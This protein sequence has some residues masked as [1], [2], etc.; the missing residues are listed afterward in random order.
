[1]ALQNMRLQRGMQPTM[2]TTITESK[3]IVSYKPITRESI[4]KV[5]LVDNNDID[6]H[7]FFKKL[8]R[9]S[10]QIPE[11]YIQLHTQYKK[12]F[13]TYFEIYKLLLKVSHIQ[14]DY[15]PNCSN[16]YHCKENNPQYGKGFVCWNNWTVAGRPK[17]ISLYSYCQEH[18]PKYDAVISMSLLDEHFEIITKQKALFSFAKNI[19]S[20]WERNEISLEER[21]V[22]TAYDWLQLRKTIQS[23]MLYTFNRS[24][25]TNILIYFYNQDIE[26]IQIGKEALQYESVIGEILTRSNLPLLPRIFKIKY[27]GTNNFA[28]KKMDYHTKIDN[29]HHILEVFTWR[30]HQEKAQQVKDYAFLLRQ[31][32]IN[33][34]QTLLVE[35]ER[36]IQNEKNEIYGIP[37]LNEKTLIDYIHNFTLKGFLNGN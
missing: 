15:T 20:L 36:Y 19:Q 11:K 27:E 32:G 33:N 35:K 25:L 37:L 22:R 29:I 23:K 2:T 9:Q 17:K 21:C 24:V 30:D 18:Q 12:E 34:I 1:M 7:L 6:Y 5:T 26:K 4:E 10:S 14:L 28:F 8:T 13:D 16:C 3:I 31:T